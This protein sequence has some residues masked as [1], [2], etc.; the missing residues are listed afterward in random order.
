MAGSGPGR[1]ALLRSVGGLGLSLGLAGCARR[2]GGGANAAEEQ[3]QRGGRITLATVEA[4]EPLA[5]LSVA[6]ASTG[7]LVDLCYASGALVEP[8]GFETV[9]WA[10]ANWEPLDDGERVGID[11]AELRW[12]DDEPLRPSDVQF[13]YEVLREHRPPRYRSVADRVLGV[14]GSDDW[15]LELVFDDPVGV[16]TDPF[17]VPL[18]PEHVYTDLDDPVGDLPDEA[19]TLGPADVEAFDPD[20]GVDLTFREEWPPLEAEWAEAYEMRGGPFLDEVRFRVH[21]SA[22]EVVAD[23]ERGA[24]DAGAF[25]LGPVRFSGERGDA[26]VVTGPDDGFEALAFNTRVEPLDDQSFRQALSM[27][28]DRERW[29]ARYQGFGDPGSTVL[30]PTFAQLRPEAAAGEEPND[31]PAVAALWERDALTPVRE[32]LDAGEAITGEAGEYAGHE[33]SESATGVETTQD[34]AR[35]EYAFVETVT[36]SL[37][38]AEVALELT[39]D[40]ERLTEYLGRPLSILAPPARGASPLAEITHGFAERVRSLGVPVEVEVASTA[41]IRE[42]AF[43]AADFDV[44]PLAWRGCS[45]HGVRTL[46]TLFHSENAVDGATGDG[47]SYNLTGYGLDEASA[48]D[49]LDDLRRERDEESRVEGVR[50]L[51]ERLYLEAPVAVV[52][53]RIAAWPINTS[54]FEGIVSDVAA[55]GGSS[56]PVQLYALKWDR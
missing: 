48:D 17:S 25:D 9:P 27:L 42:R 14:Q 7:V 37:I 6:S 12:S 36:D 22:S 47:P 46:T 38:E 51:S 24:T 35:H 53:Y 15:D 18:L 2:E 41:E 3:T 54:S 31:H 45:P 55:P 56:L 4:F 50:R 16:L 1:R 39:V 30:P 28:L 8:S 5:P 44:C 10:F 49:D 52:G 32:F 29:V 19:V 23:V 21:G 20:A 13:T 11:L 34:E 43:E 26:A 33:V 40:G